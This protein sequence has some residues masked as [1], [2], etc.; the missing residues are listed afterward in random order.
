MMINFSVHFILCFVHS[1]LT[2]AI[3]KFAKWL[4]EHVPILKLKHIVPNFVQKE[5]DYFQSK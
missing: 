5:N 4:M 3:T 2:S 1:V